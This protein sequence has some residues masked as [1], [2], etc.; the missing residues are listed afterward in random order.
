MFIKHKK[1]YKKIKKNIVHINK[2][3]NIHALLESVIQVES[4]ICKTLP[5]DVKLHISESE[6]AGRFNLINVRDGT[7]FCMLSP[8]ESSQLVNFLSTS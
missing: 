5:A 7:A 8:T 1:K 6:R 4:I 2:L 3:C